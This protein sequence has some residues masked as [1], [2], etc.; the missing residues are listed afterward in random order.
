MNLELGGEH[1]RCGPTGQ[2]TGPKTTNTQ[3]KVGKW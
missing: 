3:K 1:I 2:C